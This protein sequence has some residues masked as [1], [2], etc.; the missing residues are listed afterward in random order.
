MR[1]KLNADTEIRSSAS[2]ATLAF[3]V[4]G[5]LYRPLTEIEELMAHR[6]GDLITAGDALNKAFGDLIPG[7]KHIA[8]QDYGVLNAGM[9]WEKA[10]KEMD[11]ADH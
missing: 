5:D 9:D 7:V 6:L 10:K 1:L 11:Y 8:L 2:G 3:Y 4:R